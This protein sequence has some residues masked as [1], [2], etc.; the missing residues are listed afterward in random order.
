MTAPAIELRGVRK[1]FVIRHAAAR[2][3]QGTLLA[4][5]GRRDIRHEEFW[6]LDGVD[7]TVPRGETL[8]IIG[9][10]GSG[11]T[12]V[13]KLLARTIQPT[14]GAIHT[15][16]KVFGL[17]ELGAGMHPDLT[18]RENIFLN[19]AF[20]GLRRR[21]IQDL[22]DRIVDFAELHQFIDTPVKHYSSGMFM[23]LG[24]AI[25][26][27]VDPDILLIDEA[28]AVGDARFTAKC[29]A[30]LS[31]VKRKGRT[32][33]FVSHDPIQ[34]RRFCD[35][36]LWL[37]AGRVRMLGDPREIIQAYIRHMRIE[38]APAQPL[39][40]RTPV[41]E[42]SGEARIR[43]ALLLD[44]D[45]R[46]ERHDC[47]PGGHALLRLEL[48]TD[49]YIEDVVVGF[50]LRRSDGLLVWESSTASTI[51]PVELMPGRTQIDCRLGP[52]PLGAGAYHVSLGAWPASDRMRPFHVWPNALALFVARAAGTQRGSAVVPAQWRVSASAAHAPLESA[53][54]PVPQPDMVTV[55]GGPI[56]SPPPDRITVGHKDDEWLG[57]GWYPPEDWPP[58]VRWTTDSAR[59]YVTQG[60]GQGA[61]VLSVCRPLH[62]AHPVAA[63]V[64]IDGKRVATFRVHGM[65]FEDVVVPL[66]PVDAP[67]ALQVTIEV[68]EALVPAAVGLDDDTR[69]LGL[70]VRSIRVE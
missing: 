32:I 36:V 54:D 17:L 56:W 52:L 49:R 7:L 48:E 47:L 5:L 20:L 69:R 63:H 57:A 31:E 11:K 43:A 25:A 34:V 12:T 44:E 8:G 22:Y 51:G 55:D 67:S 10:N 9:P 13:L 15:G 16:G 38:S 4:F 59:A 23:R 68:D 6:A 29:Y 66:D 24:F 1:R 50:G 39:P 41:A 33:V 42:G 64:R 70:A 46:T 35:R 26:L 60:V 3:L 19:G 37:D 61:L 2:S 28:L 27:N 53:R 18:G 40:S 21:T 14:S 58:H 62:A 45:G 65:D 30:A